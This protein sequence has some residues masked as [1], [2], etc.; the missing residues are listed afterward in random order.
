[1]KVQLRLA[2][3]SAGKTITVKDFGGTVT[4]IM[5]AVLSSHL[6]ERAR[7]FS[8]ALFA[9]HVR[10]RSD[11]EGQLIRVIAQH[12]GDSPQDGGG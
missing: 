4:K 10:G 2:D 6:K 9:K 11:N 3:G 1:M 5:P 7:N 12:T 8:E